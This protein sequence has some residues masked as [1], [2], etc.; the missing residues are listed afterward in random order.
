MRYDEALDVNRAIKDVGMRHR[1]RAAELIGPLGLS[2]GQ[3]QVLLELDANGS[4]T[5]AQLAAAAKCEPPTM[6]MALRKL[7]AA[8]LVTRTPSPVDARAIVVAL[9]DDGAALMQQLRAAWQQLAEE[10]LAGLDAQE[11]EQ[12]IRLLGRIAD[13]LSGG[14][15]TA[16][17]EARAGA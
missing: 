4:R 13:N 16:R 12:A 2:I 7:E 5:Q 11:R 15:R 17:S 9:S 1:G 6:T 14:A 3:E 10:S 8:G